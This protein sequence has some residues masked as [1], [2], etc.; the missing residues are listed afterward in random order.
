MIRRRSHCSD[1]L[2][3][4]KQ[5][6]LFHRTNF[7][8]GWTRLSY[9]HTTCTFRKHTPLEESSL[10][11][12]PYVIQVTCIEGGREITGG[13]TEWMTRAKTQNTLDYWK[14][15]QVRI[16]H[17]A[18]ASLVTYQQDTTQ[19]DVTSMKPFPLKDKAHLAQN[20]HSISWP[21]WHWIHESK[22]HRLIYF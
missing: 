4:R 13:E 17:L 6:Y 16:L 15:Q 8:H 21:K 12:R 9:C 11:I 2:K 10:K 7:H 19:G 1:G 22:T 18:Q 5:H 20:L 14:S 3:A